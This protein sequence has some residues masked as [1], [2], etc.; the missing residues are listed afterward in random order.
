MPRQTFRNV[1][2]V[3]SAIF[4]LLSGVHY[5]W[6][7]RAQSGEA[8]I[9]YLLGTQDRILKSI[10]SSRQDREA[11]ID[12][13]L[14]RPN[15][16]F[17]DLKV[18]AAFPYYVYRNGQ[19]LFWSDH[20]IVPDFA[21]INSV[22]KHPELADFD[23]GRFLV[24][25]S[26][27]QKG[28]DSYD[29]FS[30]INLY[31]Q[32][33]KSISNLQSGYNPELFIT[34]PLSISTEKKG[35]FQNI[36]DDT[37][38]FLF[39]ISPP[40][41]DGFRI[42]STSEE[43]VLLALISF[44]LLGVFVYRYNRLLTK[45]QRYIGGF[46]CLLVYLLL[47][48][49]F[50]LY[51]NVPF[52]FNNWEVFNPRHSFSVLAPSLGD[53][54][55]NKLCEVILLFYITSCYYRCQIYRILI[56]KSRSV[57]GLVS[58]ICVLLSYVVFFT[59]YTQLVAICQKDGLMPD[60][61]LSIRFTNLKTVSLLIFISITVVYFLA[62]Q[63]LTSLFIQLNSKL[64]SGLIW[65]LAG[66]ALL[67]PGLY[68]VNLLDEPIWLLNCFYFLA[69]FLTRFPRTLYR[70]RY[71]T[72]LYLIFGAFV[73][74]LLPASVIVQQSLL[75]EIAMKRDF[76]K[77][78][79]K[80]N[81]ELGELLLSKTVKW[82]ATDTLIH[83]YLTNDRIFT[84]ERV[85]DRIQN[86]LLDLY[87]GSYDIQILIFD[88]YGQPID[89]IGS[90]E[91][92]N[93]LAIKYQQKQYQTLYSQ[94]YLRKGPAENFVMH[95]ISF[96]PISSP[97]S[98]RLGYVVLDLKNNNERAGSVYKGLLFNN[99]FIQ[100]D[101]PQN[102]S[103]AIFNLNE[104]LLYS[105]GR[106][107][108]NTFMPPGWSRNP[109]LFDEGLVVNK[110]RYLG[111]FDKNGRMIIVSSPNNPLRVLFANFSFLFLLLV[112][113]VFVVL[114]Y[115]AIRYGLAQL[116]INYTTRIQIML[117]LAF[118][119]PLLLVVAIS[120]SAIKANN[121]E[122]QEQAYI[123]NT[124]HLGISIQ[125]FLN[126][127][128]QQKRSLASLE[129]RL[130][131]MAEQADIDINIFDT[132]GHIL[133]STRPIIY[134]N[135]HLSS[136]IN[137]DA[138]IRLIAK[139]EKGALLKESLASKNF[140]TA[141][142][143]LR[144]TDG[145]LLGVLGIPYFLA[146]PEFD[147][148]IIEVTTSALNVFSLLFL[149]FWVLS[150]FAS[151]LLT[152]PLRILT[153]KIRRTSLNKLD[154]PLEWRSDDE[155]GILIHEYNRMLVKLEESKLALAQSEKISAWQEMAKQVAHEIKNP[156]TPMKLTL[157]HLQRK[158][159]EPHPDN[160]QMFRQTFDSLLDQIDNLSDIATSFSEFAKMPMPRNELFD[161]TPVVNKV[162]DLY[163]DHNSLQLHRQIATIP[164]MV[165][166]D[167]QLMSR[168]LTNLILNGIQ[169]VPPGRRP[170]LRVRLFLDDVN[171]HLEVHDNGTGIAST[172]RSKVFL[173]SF[174]TKTNGSGLGLA[175]AKRGIEHAGG[176]IWF[177]SEENK[178]TSFFI[179]LPQA[180]PAP[181]LNVEPIKAQ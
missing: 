80:T 14:Q 167:R 128:R 48:R 62:L 114:I 37:A 30:L 83:H 4:L 88:R 169:S 79:L 132:T 22:G 59:A 68:V 70:F 154:E 81:D 140:Y 67:I 170:E 101:E 121:V 93:N 175:I 91:T 119:I 134:E 176:S 63:T 158:M 27:V 118:F 136:Y 144:A 69:L 34:D 166:G 171:V 94:I 75:R 151:H 109:D 73:C 152:E 149:L 60:I 31:R 72:S 1:F 39:S 106:F 147:R 58:I 84:A 66:M 156:L 103:Y 32:Y 124:S 178:G 15:L 141:Y 10:S 155:I 177:D 148:R 110:C 40:K 173:P 102:F 131:T 117:N 24:M 181:Y 116:S 78:M 89:P 127:Y 16:S 137:P 53:L 13:I 120:L 65:F 138:Y 113:T 46:F 38:T 133:T 87:F 8:N 123:K 108:I 99:R 145:K 11:V 56:R 23:E 28:N 71:Q 150:Y 6:L 129:E 26:R 85:K 97:D 77:R 47:L 82:I 51:F 179:T 54:L 143:P 172:N 19:L 35:Q 104:G 20:H 7:D 42:Y 9:Q 45:Q 50:M 159:V 180:L 44:L 157:Q 142:A 95:Y 126:E 90:T 112:L 33:Q 135:K 43:T 17:A 160:Q 111:F 3:L 100:A 64:K 29:I 130:N 55:L 146:G 162:V 161:L 107:D 96:I 41:P 76:G 25:R 61:T 74:T 86:N 49:A 125:S 2:L 115:Y 36:F 18:Q 12:K 139:E 168:I 165:R 21:A 153:Q 52:I 174:S 98:V 5:F 163:A 105:S 92:F 164:V 122:D 57:H